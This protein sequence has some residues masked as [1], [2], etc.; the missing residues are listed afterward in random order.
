VADELRRADDDRQGRSAVFDAA[1]LSVIWPLLG[2]HIAFHRRLVDLTSSVKAALLLSQTIYWTRHGRDVARSDG[3][4]HKT[5]EQWELETGLSAKEQATA[6][7]VL[8]RLAL[9]EDQRMGIPA[10]LYFRLSMDELG[11]RLADRIASHPHAADWSNRVALAE[12]LGPSV[13]FHRTLA[14]IAGGVHAGLMLSRA[15]HLTRF[16]SRRRPDQWIASSAARWFEE[17]G[18]SR[19]EQETA[20][21]DLVRTGLWEECLRG[22]P[23]SLVAR[24]RLDCLLALLTDN[25]S[26]ARSVGS[27]D[28]DPDCGIA[29]DKASP[30]S[31]SRLRHPHSLASPKSPDQFR[32]TRE[33]GSA[34]IAVLLMNHSTSGS[35]QPQSTAS[36]VGPSDTLAG[37]GE[38]TFPEQMLPDE[39]QAAR[40]LLRHCG[41]Q[42]Q[43]LLDELA[44][45]MQVRGVRSSPVAYLRGLIARAAAG[46][47]VPELGPRVAA[48][49]EQQRQG[50]IRRREREAEEQRLAVERATPEYQARALAQR[51]K[52]RQ[53]IDELKASM[54][55][56]R[57]P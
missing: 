53:M 27:R 9:V 35:V 55:T 30:Q 57:Q 54:S 2:R 6:R 38:L 37:G 1:P 28:A 8:R 10:R 39:R 21:R 20:R 25:A 46:S 52:V 12:L 32:Q 43:C 24:I 26:M 56:G 42:A 11:A 23:P 22:I 17:I 33:H 48:A 44:G 15:L 45:R 5:T 31:K 19:R 4:F 36:S 16:Q 18:L 50:V 29:A 7:E 40:Q 51:Q 14:A 47:F 41:D 3:W 49:R 34:E 13:A